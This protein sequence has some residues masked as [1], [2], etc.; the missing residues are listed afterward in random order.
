MHI[1]RHLYNFQLQTLYSPPQHY[2]RTLLLTINQIHKASGK[3]EFSLGLITDVVGGINV[4][5][6]L[7]FTT[8]PSFVL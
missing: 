8:L 3:T 1:H 4:T 7:Y 6:C 5:V 2:A